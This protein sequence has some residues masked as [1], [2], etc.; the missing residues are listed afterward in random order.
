[1]FGTRAAKVKTFAFTSIRRLVLALRRTAI[2]KRRALR[3]VS[4]RGTGI[5]N[6]KAWQLSTFPRLGAQYHTPACGGRLPKG[7]VL[8]A[9]CGSAASSAQGGL[10][11]VSGARAAKV[12]TF[13][14]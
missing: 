11:S 14:L 7:R 3:A 4:G 13:A 12:K 10:T 6:K 9:A 5:A 1:M 2:A 8:C